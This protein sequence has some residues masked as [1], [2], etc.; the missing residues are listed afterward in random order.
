MLLGRL[1]RCGKQAHSEIPDVPVIMSRRPLQV[2]KVDMR[3][4]FENVPM[5]RRH[6][7]VEAGT[8]FFITSKSRSPLKISYA[9][10]MPLCIFIFASLQKQQF[11][12]QL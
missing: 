5:H 12:T 7:P 3:S 2:E 4:T 11:Q 6:V 1:S 10:G 9:E 8:V